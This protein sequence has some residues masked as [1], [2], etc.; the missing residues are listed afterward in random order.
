MAAA[1]AS[2]RDEARRRL[3]RAEAH[4]QAAAEDRDA[5][6]RFGLAS[7][8]ES[9]VASILAPLAAVGYT[10]LPDRA[11]PGNRRSGAQVDLIIVGPSGVHIVDTKAWKE[12]SIR[13]GRIFRGQADVSDDLANMADLA[14]NTEAL[15]A[16]VGLGALEVH[17]VA[18]L[19]GRRGIKEKVGPV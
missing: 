14:H 18:V 17:A 19:A 11:W 12:V 5:A 7:V 16:E 10:L 2:A 6:A 13:G 1:G 4:E 8:T 9:R 15:L 3:A